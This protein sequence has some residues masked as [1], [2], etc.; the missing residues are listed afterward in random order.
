MLGQWEGM[1]AP[2]SDRETA[3]RRLADI[4]RDHL[5]FRSRL[6]EVEALLVG[7]AGPMGDDA[8]VDPEAVLR[9]LEHGLSAE[10]IALARRAEA[11]RAVD[12]SSREFEGAREAL[13]TAA[14]AAAGFRHR[15]GLPP[16]VDCVAVGRRAAAARHLR[17]LIERRHLDLVGEGLGEAALRAEA[18]SGSPE[19]AAA[20]VA[21]LGE[22]EDLLVEA[23]QVAAQVSASADAA[24]ADVSARIGGVDAKGRERDAAL[25]FGDNAERWLTLAAAQ[26]LLTRAVERYRALNQHPMVVRAGEIVCELTRGH[27]NPVERL[28]AEYRDKRR[29]SLVGIRRDGS[30]CEIA[31][32]TE[33]TRDQVFLGLRIAAIER[34]ARGREPLP[35]VADDLFITSDDERTECGLRALATLAETTQVIL[36]THHL[37]VLRSAEALAASHGVATHVLP[38]GAPRS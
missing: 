13:A 35:F 25:A 9:R 11:G 29:I 3:R 17:A 24:L 20:E 12:A 14:A 16:E 27:A 7:L 1:A 22:R 8:T 37:S 23:G 34:Y 26:S 21:A 5:A 33:G 38:T 30:L 36:F 32:M 10:R 2:L 15:H 28:S 31:D 4:R 6:A 18:G 19:S